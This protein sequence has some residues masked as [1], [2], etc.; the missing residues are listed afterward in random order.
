M[1]GVNHSSSSTVGGGRRHDTRTN[2]PRV[3][4]VGATNRPDL[5]DTALTRPGRI[6]RMIYVGPPDAESRAQILRI[7][8]QKSSCSTDI[9]ISSLADDRVTG[10]C[11]GA[12]VVAICRD[13]A[14][15]ALEEDDDRNVGT[16]ESNRR[17]LRPPMIEMRHL[18]TAIQNMPRQITPSMIEF[19]KSYQE[20]VTTVI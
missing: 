19:Y 15:L 5:L 1:D 17:L 16:D 12:E 11:S 13:A 3:V 9:D 18:Y 6:D 7:T 4:V 10:G 2:P 8:L 14:L 20:Q